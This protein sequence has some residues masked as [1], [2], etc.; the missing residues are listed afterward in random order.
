MISF[1]PNRHRN[2]DKCPRIG[3]ISAGQLTALKENPGSGILQFSSTPEPVLRPVEPTQHGR[4]NKIKVLSSQYDSVV[5][6]GLQHGHSDGQE[7]S[8]WQLSFMGGDFISR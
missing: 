1:V 8:G 2:H 3:Y 7:A 6:S 4:S 5:L